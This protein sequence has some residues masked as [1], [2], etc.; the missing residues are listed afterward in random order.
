MPS[1]CF[2]FQIHQPFRLKSYDCFKIG[3]D[4]TYEDEKSNQE[5]LDRVADKCYLPANRLLLRI[6]LYTF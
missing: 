4:H 3:Y 5:I 2:Y 1:I 6:C